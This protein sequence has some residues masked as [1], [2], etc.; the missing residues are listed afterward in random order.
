MKSRFDF[1]RTILASCVILLSVFLFA[2]GGGGGGGEQEVAQL[3]APAGI[4]YTGLTTQATIADS[5]A[6]ELS[7]QSYEGGSTGS[8]ISTIAAV[9]VG[10]EWSIDRPRTLEVSQTLE[11]SL[12]QV[13]LTSRA[14]GIFSADVYSDSGTVDGNCGGSASYNISVDDQSGDFWG[15]FT[16]SSYCS[17]GVVISGGVSCS[18][19]VDVDTGDLL[20]F[21][22]SFDSLTGTKGNESYTLDGNIS[23]DVTGSPGIIKMTMLLQDNT[24]AKVYWV[25]NFQ[26]LVTDGAGYVQIEMSG[27]FYHPDYG[28]VVVSTPEPFLINDS[29][30]NPSDGVLVIDGK[31]GFAGGSTR[32]R[33]EAHSATLCQVWADTNGDGN[34]NW[35]SGVINWSDL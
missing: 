22:F 11:D 34:Y 7:T 14:G 23:C 32:A 18:G 27:T 26:I 8:A 9:A 19:Q 3:Q 16:Y 12:R 25:N 30:D 10:S 24:T 17:E 6:Q 28:Y 33:L 13:D 35:D 29:D 21:S 31:T 15:S 5:N 2:C 4:S 20:T 1:T